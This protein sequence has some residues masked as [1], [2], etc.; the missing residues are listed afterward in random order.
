[1]CVGRAPI[2]VVDDEC[3]IREVL[4][5]A[6]Q[7]DGYR[8]LTARDGRDALRK[9][10]ICQPI[11]ILLDLSMPGMDG[12]T[13]ADELQ[14]RGLR[15]GIPLLLMSASPRAQMCADLIGAERFV[16]KPFELDHILDEVF[17]L[18]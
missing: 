6:L 8:V 10:E 17:K 14:R 15:P 5:Q 12:L 13:F 16:A 18:L 9:L 11:L 3:M 2:L 7:D 1:M 4:R